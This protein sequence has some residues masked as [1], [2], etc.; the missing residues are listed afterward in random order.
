MYPGPTPAFHVPIHGAGAGHV[1]HHHPHHVPV[2][3][4]HNHNRPVQVSVA[5][6]AQQPVAV[7][8]EPDHVPPLRNGLSEEATLKILNQASLLL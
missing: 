6:Q 8:V 2:Q 3:Y 5:V 1:P 7:V 4:H